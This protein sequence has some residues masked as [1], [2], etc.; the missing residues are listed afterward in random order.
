MQLWTMPRPGAATLRS[1]WPGPR[2][3]PALVR[4]PLPCPRLQGPGSAHTV[5]NSDPC[6]LPPEL[7]FAKSIMKI[8]EAGKVSIHQQVAM[9]RPPTPPRA[10]ALQNRS[11]DPLDPQHLLT[12]TFPPQSHMPLQYI[13]TLF[14]EHDLSLGAL[15]METVAQQK[16]DYYQVRGPC[17]MHYSSPL[18]LGGRHYHQCHFAHEEAEAQ[19]C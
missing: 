4:A 5:L 16:R 8:A 7:E 12:P 17:C 11:P 15:A 9:S 2:R 19:G 18:S 14:L 10:Q 6:C 1:Y 3:E 13:Y